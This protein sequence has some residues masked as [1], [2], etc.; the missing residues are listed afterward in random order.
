M[1]RSNLRNNFLKLKTEE[2]WLAYNRQRYYCV[3]LLRLEQKE[4]SL[5]RK[6]SFPLRISSVN[7]TTFTEVENF[8]EIVM[9]NLKENFIF[10]AVV[11][12]PWRLIV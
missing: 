8:L 10:C 6:G 9:E 12:K 11:L 5:H 2:N 3:K 1:V 4:Y 7:V